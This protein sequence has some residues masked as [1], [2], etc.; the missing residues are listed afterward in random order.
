ME[1]HSD[2]RKVRDIMT[3]TPAA[4]RP[5]MSVRELQQ[6]FA[7]LDYNAFPVVD[8]A[9]AL[10]GIVTKLDVLRIYR[11]DPLRDTPE[12]EGIRAQSV[13]DVMRPGVVTLEPD[14]PLV[15]AVDLMVESRLQSLPVVERRH[16]AGPALVGMVSR[17]DLL[18]ALSQ[19]VG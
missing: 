5:G 14:D 17:G 13:A 7:N 15:A 11:P 2:F 4:V 9:G 6:M 10:R 3:S 19:E 18:R 16:G 1:T 8:E 12:L